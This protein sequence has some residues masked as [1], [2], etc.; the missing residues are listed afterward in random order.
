MVGKRYLAKPA[1]IR[2]SNK[3][4]YSNNNN[5]N[6][7]NYNNNNTNNL[8]HM[9]ALIESR[10]SIQP[11]YPRYQNVSLSP[12]QAKLFANI[13]A[14]Y[15]DPETM[16]DALVSSGISRKNRNRLTQKIRALYE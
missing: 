7:W 1:H 12:E 2:F 16:K 4:S 13:S 9:N 14:L 6:T 11:S 10:R 5:N 8:A 3:N 15:N